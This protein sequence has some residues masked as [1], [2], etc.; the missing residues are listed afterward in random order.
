MAFPKTNTVSA[1]AGESVELQWILPKRRES[2][3]EELVIHRLEQQSGQWQSDASEIHADANS[4]WEVVSS[5]HSGDCWYTGPNGPSSMVLEEVFV[6]NASASL[7]FWISRRLGTATFTVEIS[8]NAGLSYIAL[9]SDQDH[10]SLSWEQESISL[11]AYA[12]QQIRLRFALSSGSYYTS[13]GVWLDDLAISSGN[14]FAWQPFITDDTLASRRFSE[15]T[16]AWDDCDDF[17][18]FEETSTST[19]KEWVCSTTSG[20]ANCFYKQPGGYTNHRYHLTSFST[21]TPTASTRLMLHGKYKLY[22]D[23]FRVM[24]STDGA[25]FTE[26]WSTQGSVDWSDIAVDLSMYAGQ[27]VYVRLEYYYNSGSHYTTGG[28]WIDS[29]STQ[30]VTNPELEGQPVHYTVLTNLPGGIHTL[31]A[32]LEDTNAVTHGFAPAFTLT[33]DDGD[34][35]PPEWEELYGLDPDVNDGLLDPDEDGYGNFDE[36]ICGTVPTNAASCWLLEAGA[37]GMPPVFYAM[38]ERPIPFYIALGLISGA[39][40]AARYRYS[41]IERHGYGGTYDSATNRPGSIASGPTGGLRR[42]DVQRL[43]TELELL[44]LLHL[45][46]VFEDLTYLFGEGALRH[47]LV[48]SDQAGVEVHRGSHNIVHIHVRLNLEIGDGGQFGAFG[49]ILEIGVEHVV[50]N[51]ILVL[52]QAVVEIFFMPAHV[53]EQRPCTLLAGGFLEVFIKDAE[54]PVELPRVF[55]HIFGLIECHEILPSL[56][57]DFKPPRKSVNQP[58][59]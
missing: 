58:V 18:I 2:E 30:E 35:M 53:V 13:G 37:G 5:G 34:G 42:A 6:P 9:Y 29:I 48:E 57:P 20:V 27:A 38:E 21:I 8:T 26:I 49:T 40:D 56:C 23:S 1:V 54:F 31:A 25:V 16:T 22:D 4:G 33:V 51:L 36:Y 17:S 15:I 52:G 3:A 41:G 7:T 46:Q 12:G 24:V 45:Q 50:R 59:V 28:V 11:A 10:Y 19:Y 47:F 44:V 14:W 39:L 55:K 43:L 32:A